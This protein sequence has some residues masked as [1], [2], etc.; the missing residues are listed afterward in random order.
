[1]DD[2]WNEKMRCPRC[3]HTGMVGLSQPKGT[4]IPIVDIMPDGFKVVKS[5]YGI[6][7][8]CGSCKVEVAV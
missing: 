1:M 8:E 4:Y 6:N 5:E 3:H 7:F 2:Q